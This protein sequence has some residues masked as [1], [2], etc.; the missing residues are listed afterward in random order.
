MQHL[1]APGGL[2]VTSNLFLAQYIGEFPEQK[3]A[4]DY[5][6]AVL[7]REG[8]LTTFVGELATSVRR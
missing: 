5:R 8:W 7:D 3:E 4:A 1:V 6:E 2:L